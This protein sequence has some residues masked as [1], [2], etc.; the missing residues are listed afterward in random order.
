MTVLPSPE[1]T[2]SLPL[3]RELGVAERFA[4]EMFGYL[5]LL[6]MEIQQLSRQVIQPVLF[7]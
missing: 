6:A 7:S 1:R 2:S 3:K 4:P 5:A